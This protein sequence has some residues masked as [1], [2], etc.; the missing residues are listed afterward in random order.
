MSQIR[1]LAGIVAISFILTA[2]VATPSWSSPTLGPPQPSA[3]KP[4]ST[5]STSTTN[6]VGPYVPKAPALPPAT[7][8][9]LPPQIDD[10]GD[11]TLEL[12]AAWAK[13]DAAAKA[14]GVE[15]TLTTSYRTREWQEQA[16]AE[17]TITYG[18]AEAARQWVA[19]PWE[20]AHV[21]GL[22]I[23][24]GPSKESMAWLEANQTEFG[25]CRRYLNEEWH[26]EVL[27]AEWNGICPAM[28]PTAAS[29]MR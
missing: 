4:V 26:F 3:T 7:P 16:F 20:T 29:Y 6:T 24:V 19:L 21:R 25:L 2:T 13:A 18:S 8:F 17:A 9:A 28:L 23:D 15:L 12:K 10:A 22:A 14:A 1:K 5:V 27:R 11:M